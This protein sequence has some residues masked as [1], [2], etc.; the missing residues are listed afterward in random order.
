V[1]VQGW[2]VY[3]GVVLVSWRRWGIWWIKGPDRDVGWLES[4]R[5]SEKVEVKGNC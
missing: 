4:M 1:L 2:G 5:R 3:A